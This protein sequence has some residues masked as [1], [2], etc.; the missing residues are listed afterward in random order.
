MSRKRHDSHRRAGV[1]WPIIA[2]GALLLVGAAVL[3]ARQGGADDG[4]GGTPQISVDDQKIDFGY[5]KFGETRTFKVAVTNKGS[6]PLR[7]T[8]KPYVEV[9]EGC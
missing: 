5:V 7:F 8:S 1:A 3:L 4:G 2:F 6:G 9:L